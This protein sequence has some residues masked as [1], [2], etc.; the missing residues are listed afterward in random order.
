MSRCKN[1]ITKFLQ[2]DSSI[3]ICRDCG[4]S[5]CANSNCSNK[6][7]SG[8]SCSRCGSHSRETI[9]GR[10]SRQRKEKDNE[11]KRLE[12]EKR[13]KRNSPSS[14]NTSAFVGLFA[15]NEARKNRKAERE[16]ERI[17][18]LVDNARNIT[19]EYYTRKIQEDEYEDDVEE[20]YQEPPRHISEIKLDADYLK[21]HFEEKARRE[22]VEFIESYDGP[23]D[24]DIIE[25]SPWPTVEP[26]VKQFEFED[27]DDLYREEVRLLE[28]K[29]RENEREYKKVL[30][31]DFKLLIKKGY[32]LKHFLKLKDIDYKGKFLKE[33]EIRKLYNKLNPGWFEKLCNFLAI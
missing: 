15:L 3:Y 29:E 2:C 26:T 25:E 6:A 30:K 21:A 19:D 10:Q 18:E 28:E 1:Y 5:G 24:D 7:F 8:S 31:E 20:P 32:K 27:I 23:T 13:E 4:N 17:N 11:R 14:N 16:I 12:S 22:R 9:D 33:Q